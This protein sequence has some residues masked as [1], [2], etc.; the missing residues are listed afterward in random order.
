MKTAQKTVKHKVYQHSQATSEALN[1]PVNKT[2]IVCVI[3]TQKAI[4]YKL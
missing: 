2:C 3:S 4:I 1:L